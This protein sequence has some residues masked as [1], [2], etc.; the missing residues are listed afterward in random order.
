[1]TDIAARL[2][3]VPRSVGAER[4]DDSRRIADMMALV[5]AQMP[6]ARRIVHAGDAIHT[7]GEPFVHLFVLNSG[8]FKIINTAADGR[9]QMVALNF[10]GDWLGFDGIARGH[11]GCDAVAMDT[12]EVWSLRYETLIAASLGHP[13]LLALLH[14]QMSR[15]ITRDRDSMLALCTLGAD[16][17][18]ADFLRYWADSLARRG[19][20]TDQITLRM[21]RAEIGNFLGMTLETVSRALSRLARRG[22]IRFNAKGRRDIEIPDIDA[23]VDFI[24]SSPRPASATLQ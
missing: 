17:R 1:M 14:D 18:V 10:K 13:P 21:S 22:A 19:L 2:E 4:Q 9:E 15:E 24:Q 20:R 6:V 11:Y 5:S 7:A 12:G 23:L 3:A 8:L 16:A